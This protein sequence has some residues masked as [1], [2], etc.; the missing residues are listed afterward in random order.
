MSADS[1]GPGLHIRSGKSPTLSG[2]A[3]LSRDQVGLARARSLMRSLAPYGTGLHAKTPF[4][5]YAEEASSV[6]IGQITAENGLAEIRVFGK[7]RL[8][9]ELADALL[10]LVAAVTHVLEAQSDLPAALAP[11]RSALRQVDNPFE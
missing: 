2:E 11:D 1:E 3:V 5:P 10:G 6:G 4:R 9:S 8:T 7:D